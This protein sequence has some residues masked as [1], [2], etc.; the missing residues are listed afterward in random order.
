VHTSAE[1]RARWGTDAVPAGFTEI[2]E[3]EWSL[4]GQVP[5]DLA[6]YGGYLSVLYTG[7]YDRRIRGE[8]TAYDLRPGQVR[9]P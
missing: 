3:G 7:N 6:T 2:Q 5:P 4:D 9:T 1:R 8:M